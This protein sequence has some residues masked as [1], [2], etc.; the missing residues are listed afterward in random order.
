[1]YPAKTKIQK[2]TCTPGF[3]AVLLAIDM[4]AISMP[5]KERMG[6]DVARTYDGELL[7]CK[8]EQSGV[9]CREVD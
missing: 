7:S 1:M 4:E 2:D 9:I 5:I 8:K 6:K 3:T